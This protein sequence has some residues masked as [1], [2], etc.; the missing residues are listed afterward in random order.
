MN[1][2]SASRHSSRSLSLLLALAL[3]SLSVLSLSISNAL[4][5]ASNWRVHQR[6]RQLAA[7][8]RSQGCRRSANVP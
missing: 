6:A 2:T 1:I 7:A 5:V 8:A 3:I 4:Q